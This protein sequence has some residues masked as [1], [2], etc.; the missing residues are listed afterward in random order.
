[1][2]K[3]EKLR[4][5]SENEEL[6]K[7]KVALLER[8]V[9]FKAI[10]ENIDEVFW[11]TD[12]EIK[13]IFYVSPAYEMISGQTCE[14]LYRYPQ[15]FFDV[16]YSEDRKQV[17]DALDL[18]KTGQKFECECRVLKPDGSVRWV[19]AR[20][21]PVMNSEEKITVYVG[22]IRDITERK[23]I[24]DTIRQGKQFAESILNAV[25]CLV[26]ILDDRGRILRFN[27]YAEKTTGY[28]SNEVE[29]KDWFDTF[30]SKGET[31]PVVPGEPQAGNGV[32]AHG[33]NKFLLTKD[34]RRVL[35]EWSNEPLRD[36]CGQMIGLIVTGH[37]VTERYRI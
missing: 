15:S 28:R 9:G 35:I 10:A 12:P 17:L 22:V 11:A 5:P 34:G 7:A 13:E 25:Q 18:M 21:F 26:V 3:D 31:L 33:N 24:V 6:R 23:N 19:L 4:V 29:G 27:S 1:M 16:I 8:G 32:A 14:S 30:L 36:E 20:G 2:E 37:D